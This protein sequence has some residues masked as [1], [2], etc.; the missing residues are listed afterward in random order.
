MARPGEQDHVAIGNAQIP[1]KLRGERIMRYLD[2]YLQ[3]FN[4]VEEAVQQIIEAFLTWETFGAQRDFVLDTIG[5][6][7]DQPRPDGFDNNQYAFIL[8]ARVR[9]RKS[10]GTMADVYVVANFLAQG[11]TVRIFGLVPK[12]LV[13]VFV[14]LILTPQEAAIYEQILLASIDAVDQLELQTVPTGTAFYDFG[15]YDEELYAP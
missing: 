1:E 9:S 3:Q 7:F 11:K 13:V 14:D 2:V 12:V 10:Q 8:R 6:L 5:S 4:D 15:E